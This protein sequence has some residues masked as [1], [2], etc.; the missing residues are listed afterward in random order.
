M[1]FNYENG[2]LC[3]TIV[4]KNEDSRPI[5]Y[6]IKTTSPEKFRVRPSTGALSPGAQISVNVVLQP[7]YHIPGLLRDKFLIM[8]IPIQVP[9]V[10]SQDLGDLWKQVSDKEVQQHRLRCSV[11][12]V[13]QPDS[14]L[15]N[16]SILGPQTTDDEKL[17][18]LSKDVSFFKTDKFFFF[19]S[20]FN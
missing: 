14:V 16:G 1:S 3:G 9:D 19:F 5:S 13:G 2:E 6:K 12:Q 17:S 10:T 4:L 11:A 7:G 20:I 18:K 8:S 15:K